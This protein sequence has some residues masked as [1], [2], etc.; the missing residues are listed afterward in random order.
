M[1]D[2]AH[3]LPPAAAPPGAPDPLG[4][5]GTWDP[6]VCSSAEALAAARVRL[7]RALES[8]PCVAA[9]GEQPDPDHAAREISAAYLARAR[10]AG[11]LPAEAGDAL[12]RPLA[13]RLRS[14]GT[15]VEA[16]HRAERALEWM[17]LAAR[18]HGWRRDPGPGGAERD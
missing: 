13:E 14:A 11:L 6:T 17:L 18:R 3:A 4:D 7:E 12:L 8:C 15:P 1:T 2:A 9:P 10:E 5:P 16:L